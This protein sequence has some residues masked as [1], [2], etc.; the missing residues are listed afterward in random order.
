MGDATI[1]AKDIT[2]DGMILRL[3]WMVGRIEEAGS[4]IPR[5]RIFQPNRGPRTVE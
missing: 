2:Y 5:Q 3:T 4:Q 1:V